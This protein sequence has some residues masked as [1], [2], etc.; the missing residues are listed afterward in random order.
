MLTGLP[1]WMPGKGKKG[2]KNLFKIGLRRGLALLGP[3]E[4]P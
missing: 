2:R 4:G 1:R 3:R